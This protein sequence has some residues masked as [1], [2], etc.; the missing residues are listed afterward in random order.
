MRFPHGKQGV[1]VYSHPFLND[2]QRLV[3]QVA[4]KHFA[5]ADVD[6]AEVFA[7]HDVDMRRI[8]LGSEEV[9]FDDHTVE[10]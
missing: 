7:V 2:L 4:F 10:T 1:A 9:H 5:R 6:N 8:V 3:R